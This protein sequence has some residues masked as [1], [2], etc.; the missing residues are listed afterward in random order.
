MFGIYSKK[1]VLAKLL[2]IVTACGGGHSKDEVNEKSLE[3]KISSTYESYISSGSENKNSFFLS[4]TNSCDQIAKAYKNELMSNLYTDYIWAL[5]RLYHEDNG[6]IIYQ[7]GTVSNTSHTKTNT[8][9]EGVDESDYVKTDGQYIYQVG[10]D[11]NLRVFS[12]DMTTQKTIEVT[13]D[14]DEILNEISK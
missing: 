4:E 9:V 12:K 1:V 2:L 6:D 8:Q 3:K 11:G 10:I 13:P 5:E 14:R 7:E